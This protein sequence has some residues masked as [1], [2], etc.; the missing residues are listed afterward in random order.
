MSKWNFYTAKELKP[1]GW[2]KRQL[3]IQAEGLCGKLDEVWPDVGES[4]WIGGNWEAWERMPYWLDGF[5]PLAYLLENGDMIARAKKYMDTIL[6]NQENDGW[7]CPCKEAERIKYDTWALQLFT[8]VMVVYYECSGDERIPEALYRVLRNYY[9]LLEAG[10]IKLFGWAQYRWFETLIAIRFVHKRCNEDWLLELATILKEQGID[11]TENEKHWYT[12]LYKVILPTHIVGIAMMLKWEALCCE[13]LGDEYQ[14]LA[15]EYYDILYKYNGTPVELFTGDEHL[16]GLSPIHGTELC[17]VVEQMYSYE[18][19]FAYTGDNKWAERL[20]VVAFN[21]LP[22]TI[23]EDTWTHQYVQQSNQIACVEFPGKSIFGTVGPAANTFGLAPN[24]GCCTANYGQGW[25]KLA[26][27]AY[28]YNGDTVLNSLMIPAELNTKD[29]HISL[30]T[31]Y[32]FKNTATYTIKSKKDF[33]FKIRIPSFAEKLRVDGKPVVA[34]DLSFAIMANTTR[35]IS[36]SFETKPYFLERPYDLHTV[37]CG[38][39][40]FSVPIQYKTKMLEYVGKTGAVR[41]FPYCDYH[42]FPTTDWNYGYVRSKLSVENREVSDVPY[43]L[44][45]PPVVV[46]ALVRK[47]DWG[48]EHGYDTVCAKVPNSRTPLSETEE[49]VLVPYGCAKLRMTELP[50]VKK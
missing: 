45:K 29:I 31:E 15:Q 11:F 2:I 7:I 24:Y 17:A 14:D 4:G 3:E 9:D 32:P 46:K 6:E 27:F 23:S 5:V 43:S 37:K 41:K 16:A 22:A 36:V 34:D 19:L 30:K 20:E 25:P 35:E 8:K 21:A 47:I 10:Q 18:H 1:R 42:L 13:L 26:L 12:P 48:Y 39:L 28:V 50:F 38:S 33:T 49:M 40:V 44:E